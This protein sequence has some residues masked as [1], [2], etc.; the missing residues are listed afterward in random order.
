[1]VLITSSGRLWVRSSSTVLSPAFTRVWVLRTPWSLTMPVLP[2][3]ITTAS[4]RRRWRGYDPTQVEALLSR[5]GT[6]YS[7]AL[8]RIATLAEERARY[9]ADQQQLQ[10]R[11]DGIGDSEAQAG[12]HAWRAQLAARRVA[13]QVVAGAV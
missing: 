10:R 6:D 1:M 7:G 3:E 5:I 9:R 13:R 12:L 2:E 8:D 4:L 11:L